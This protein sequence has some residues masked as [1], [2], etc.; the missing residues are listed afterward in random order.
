MWNDPIV[1]RGN[2]VELHPMR[3]DHLEAMFAAGCDPITWRWTLDN[4]STSIEAMRTY[5][6]TALANAEAGIDQPFVQVLAASQEV[7]GSTRVNAVTLADRS[8]EIG[9]TWITPKWTR[10]GVNTEAKW[11]LL[12][13]CFDTLDAERVQLK[14]DDRNTVSQAAIQRIGAKFE[15]VLRNDRTTWDGHRR[16]THMFSI[17]RSE[18]PEVRERLEAMLARFRAAT[19]DLDR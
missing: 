1:I 8:F 17:L 4:A 16:S 6:E 5:M 19:I 11:L 12:N 3:P 15:G 10:T 7:I 2:I 18:W 13:H 14:T 9:W